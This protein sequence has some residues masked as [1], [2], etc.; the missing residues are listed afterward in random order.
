MTKFKFQLSSPVRLEEGD[1]DGVEHVVM[2][3]SVVFTRPLSEKVQEF[4]G[5]QNNSENIHYSIDFTHL[6][7]RSG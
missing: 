4:W 6:S 7:C 5:I 3:I 1:E 2:T